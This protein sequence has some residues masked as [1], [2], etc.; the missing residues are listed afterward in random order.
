MDR[1]IVRRLTGV[2]SEE[3]ILVTGATGKSGRRVVAQLRAMGLPVRAATRPGFDWTDSGTWDAALDG[4]R[5]VYLVQLD[6]TK[7]VRPFVERARH[8]GVRRLVLA[9]GR[10]IDNP[11]Y[12]IDSGGIL[13]GLVDSED[14]VRAS[15]LEWT[16]TRPGW[17]AQNFSEGFFSDAVRAGELRLPAGDGAASFVDAAD[18]AEVVVAALTE[19]R[20]A[21]QIYELSGP[22]A[23][24]LTEAAATISAAA[25]REVRYVPLSVEDY[26]AE[27]LAQGV[28]RQLAEAFA[29]MIAP[30]RDGADEYLSDGVQRALGRA[31]RSFA[32][33][34]HATS[35]AV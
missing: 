18:I 33:F 6:G 19:D 21:G 34:A 5:A 25:G 14:A 4:V 23:I 26:I 15:G 16:I 27:L 7:L 11:D 13:P 12:A 30:L 22:A 10:G 28:P 20:H 3:L 17:F 8:H 2:M 32:E 1:L 35:W 29:D 24:S 9:S 31:P